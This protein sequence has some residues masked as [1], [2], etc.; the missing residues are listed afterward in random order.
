MPSVAPGCAV[1]VARHIGSAGGHSFSD[2]RL[3]VFEGQLAI[4]GVQ[5]FGLLAV[6]GMAQFGDPLPGSGLPSNREREV[7]L[8]FGLGAQTRHFGLQDHKR[9]LQSGRESIQIK[10]LR[11]V[12][13]HTASYPIHLQKPIFTKRSESFCRSWSGRPWRMN[14]APLASGKQSPGL[15]SD[16]PHPANNASNCT[17]DSRM[18]PSPTCRQAKLPCS[19]RL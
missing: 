3:K 12:S 14:A 19:S 1:G 18:T 9:L 8:A 17:R 6:E 13:G 4:V 7:I 11:G 2:S 5:L 15:F 10:G 16:P